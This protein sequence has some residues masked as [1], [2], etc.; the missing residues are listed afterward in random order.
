MEAELKTKNSKLNIGVNR[1]AREVGNGPVNSEL[2]EE[3]VDGA[4]DRKREMSEDLDL[5]S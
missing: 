4:K 5:K 1:P 2:N 3:G